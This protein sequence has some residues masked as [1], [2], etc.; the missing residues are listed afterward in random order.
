MIPATPRLVFPIGRTSFSSMRRACPRRLTRRISSLPD[1]RIELTRVSPSSRRTAVVPRAFAFL[2]SLVGVFF[3]TPF[4]VA[5]KRNSSSLKS[6]R[7]TVVV[8]S[9][10]PRVKNDFT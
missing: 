4:A 3:T 5:I 9:S 8:I 2:N 10:F 7:A 1:V 6:L